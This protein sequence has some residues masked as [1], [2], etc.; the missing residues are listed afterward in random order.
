MKWTVKEKEHLTHQKEPDSLMARVLK[1]SVTRYREQV[2]PAKAIVL[3]FF[4]ILAPIFCQLFSQL[5]ISIVKRLNLL[6][7]CFSSVNQ[8]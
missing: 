1:T 7:Q 8:Y 6:S 5:K 3:L 2:Y 4:S